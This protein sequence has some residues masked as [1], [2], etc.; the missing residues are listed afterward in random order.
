MQHER[1]GKLGGGRPT[2]AHQGRGPAVTMSCE[3]LMLI[4]ASFSLDQGI[5]V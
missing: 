5:A 1:P 2:A 4:A 3:R